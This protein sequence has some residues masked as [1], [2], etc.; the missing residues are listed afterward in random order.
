MKKPRFLCNSA[1]QIF[2]DGTFSFLSRQFYN[3]VIHRLTKSAVASLLAF[4][5]PFSGELCEEL[6]N[7]GK[8]IQ[9]DFAI[10]STL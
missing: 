9:N 6:L 5:G 7:R 8:K 2:T 1:A 4:F 10:T 3:R